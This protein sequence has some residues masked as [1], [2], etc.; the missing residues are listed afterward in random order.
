MEKILF[1]REKAN[2]SRLKADTTK[3]KYKH[4]RVEVKERQERYLP[5]VLGNTS[6]LVLVDLKELLVLHWW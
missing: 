2:L 3:N 5:K 6:E 4:R 1:K